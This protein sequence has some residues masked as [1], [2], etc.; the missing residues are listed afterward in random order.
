MHV[1]NLI[2]YRLTR[3]QHLF[4]F[5]WRK[6]RLYNWPDERNVQVAQVGLQNSQRTES[7][8]PGHCAAGEAE[9]VRT[10]MPAGHR[11][12]FCGLFD[13]VNGARLHGTSKRQKEREQVR[14]VYIYVCMYSVIYTGRTQEK[15]LLYMLPHVARNATE[16]YAVVGV[17]T[18]VIAN[19]HHPK[20]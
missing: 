3:E 16:E 15:R 1:P 7:S 2:K 9:L 20:S 5:S 18:L 4:F 17:R 6:A 12:W 8:R 13:A 14:S 11:W 19:W 10:E